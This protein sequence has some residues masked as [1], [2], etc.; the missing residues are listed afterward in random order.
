MGARE[1][2]P[3]NAH[4]HTQEVRKAKLNRQTIIIMKKFKTN[5]ERQR[6]ITAASAYFK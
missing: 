2:I 6:G 5:T 4:T 3:R 1:I